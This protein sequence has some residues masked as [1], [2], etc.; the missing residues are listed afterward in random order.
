M[1]QTDVSLVEDGSAGGAAAGA[2]APGQWPAA[3]VAVGRNVAVVGDVGRPPA[4]LDFGMRAGVLRIEDE[5]S[6]APGQA[7][8]AGQVGLTRCGPKG[9]EARGGGGRKGR[10][11]SQK[12]PGWQLDDRA[13]ALLVLG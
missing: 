10:G 12:A 9:H 7:G 5:V 11:R 8:V 3:G 13:C 2:C 6:H 4:V 1:L